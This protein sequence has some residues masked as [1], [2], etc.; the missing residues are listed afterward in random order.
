[1][2]ITVMITEKSEKLLLKEMESSIF[3]TLL[4]KENIFMLQYHQCGLLFI[5]MIEM[6][7]NGLSKKISVH[8]IPHE[9]QPLGDHQEAKTN[10]VYPGLGDGRLDRQSH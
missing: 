1:M 8:G 3:S 7:S 9:K 5:L 6:Q 2:T 10:K 4:L